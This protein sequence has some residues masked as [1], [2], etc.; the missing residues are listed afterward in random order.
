MVYHPAGQVEQSV[1]DRGATGEPSLR[2]SGVMVY[3][4]VQV[5]GQDRAGHPRRIGEE[6]PRWT[7]NQSGVV[8]DIPHG[9]LYY[10]DYPTG[11]ERVA[12]VVRRSHLPGPAVQ[13]E[14]GLQGHLSRQHGPTIAVSGGA[15]RDT[16]TL[17]TEQEGQIRTTPVLMSEAGIGDET[18]RY[19]WQVGFGDFRF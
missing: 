8:F 2:R 4:P 15:F 10:D 13:L 3:P 11:H 6:P 5:V 18:F 12:E 9:R 19:R 14:S 7:V 17:D 1:A 16:W